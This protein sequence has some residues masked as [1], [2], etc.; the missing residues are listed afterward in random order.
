MVATERP[1]TDNSGSQFWGGGFLQNLQQR[2]SPVNTD[3]YE[4]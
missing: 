4:P 2:E 1:V 3:A